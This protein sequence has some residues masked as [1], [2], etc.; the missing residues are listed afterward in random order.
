VKINDNEVTLLLDQDG[1]AVM[2]LA[3]VDW[4]RAL[5]KSATATVDGLFRFWQAKFKLAA[6]S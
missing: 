4:I 2:Q 3:S 1:E 5:N 6:R